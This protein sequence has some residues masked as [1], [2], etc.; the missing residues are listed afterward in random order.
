MNETFHIRMSRGTAALERL[1]GVVRFRGFDV[2]HM[3][4]HAKDDAEFEI[5]LELASRRGRSNLNKHLIKIQDVKEV[6]R[7][8]FAAGSTSASCH[9]EGPRD[10]VLKEGVA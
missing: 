5:V 2:E 6:V 7:V 3:H 4:L 9:A 8:E 10:F 1:L